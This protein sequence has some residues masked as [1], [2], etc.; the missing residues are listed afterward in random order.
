M[1]WPHRGG[2]V[3]IQSTRSCAQ[4]VRILHDAPTH[5]TPAGDRPDGVVA[6]NPQTAARP[7]ALIGQR[8]PPRPRRAGRSWTLAL[9]A[10]I[11]LA[12]AAAGMRYGWRYTVEQYAVAKGAFSVELSGPGTLDAI[13]K[14]TISA[15]VQ[16]RLTDIFVDRN[17]H[18]A[19]GAIIARI[20][21]DDLKSQLA[22]AAASHEAAKR[23]VSQ[24][25]ADRARSEAT[26][27]NAEAAFSRQA[28]LIKQG[29]TTQASYDSALAALRQSEADLARAAAAI[30]ASEAQ[31]RAAAATVQVNQA[32]LEEAIIRAPFAGTVVSRDR[33][34]GDFVTPGAS[35]VQL[36]DPAT[37][38]L[39]A[40]FDES[41][42]AAV[43]PGQT[44]TLK[45]TSQPERPLAGRVL[46]LGRQVDTETREFTV[47]I[48]PDRLPAN[49]AI[50]QR[51]TAAITIAQDSGVVSVP[52]RFVVR[53]G[54]QPGVW[55]LA[56]GRARWRQLVLGRFGGDRVEVRDG[57]GDGDRVLAPSGAFEWM[58][59]RTLE[60][61]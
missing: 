5:P 24:A 12:A 18:A 4:S 32:Q 53:R 60:V 44:V 47:D 29:W 8:P 26:L 11:L 7:D 43:Q 28:T 9:A 2:M 6:D 16:G 51:G 34:L 3:L 46:R 41:A 54:G 45:F 17:D 57:L 21:S 13:A 25:R 30:D 37:I 58:A 33:N 35:I 19:R 10:A 14:A 56:D 55:V 49:W 50:G 48:V 40:R 59:V 39:T 31:E 52:S 27:V 23:A 15:R 38:V 36:V 22:V 42:I 61:R 20:S 1:I